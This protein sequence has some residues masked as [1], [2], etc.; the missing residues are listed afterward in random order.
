MSEV[1][2]ILG[3]IED[4]EKCLDIY[5][6]EPFFQQY[7]PTKEGMQKI[8][9][10]C[11]SDPTQKFIIALDEKDTTLGFALFDTKGAFSRSGYLRLIVVATQARKKR[12]GEELMKHLEEFHTGPS[13]LCLL[14]TA[15]N[16]EAQKFY[17]KLGYAK[18][19]ELENYVKLGLNEYIFYKKELI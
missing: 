16:I 5:F 8:F 7:N 15:H 3:K 12:V 2:I 9:H 14:V 1:R 11:L 4:I 6:S 10:E 19:G 17:H 18:V 13:G